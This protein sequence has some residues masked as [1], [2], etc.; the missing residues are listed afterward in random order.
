MSTLNEFLELPDISG[1]TS[2]IAVEVGG[3]KLNLV[4]RP[5]SDEDFKEYQR[6]S[7]KKQ[8]NN[9]TIDQQKLRQCIL[10]S[11][12]VE[13][14]FA[15]AEFLKKVNCVTSYQFLERKFPA[16]VLQDIVS[17]VLEISGFMSD[18]NVEIDEAK[19]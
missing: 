7:Q 4:V 18:I 19:N 6:R 13:P 11:H 16:G 3:K 15:D 2:E 17:K 8:G 10:E 12:I 9:I 14:N 1:I 5:I